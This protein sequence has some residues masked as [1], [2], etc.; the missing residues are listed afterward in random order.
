MALDTLDQYGADSEIERGGLRG[1]TGIVL[2]FG[3]FILL[4]NAFL[5][6]L[7]FR[8]L[9]SFRNQ[10]L[11]AAVG[12]GF[13]VI[14]LVLRGK[15]R[16]QIVTAAIASTAAIVATIII[17]FVEERFGILLLGAAVVLFVWLIQ[18]LE[19]RAWKNL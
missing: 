2:T 13:G 17:Q 5:V 14:G 16:S 12:A 19:E 7:L 11:C 18:K 3:G 10:L 1:L 6:A 8:H 9:L 4:A 15:K